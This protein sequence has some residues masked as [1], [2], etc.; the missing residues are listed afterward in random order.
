MTASR[1][2]LTTASLGTMVALVAFTAPLAT[3]NLTVAGLGAGTSGG[4]GSSAR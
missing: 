3:V 1:R 2:T 4:P